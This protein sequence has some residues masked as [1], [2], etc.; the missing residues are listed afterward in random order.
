MDRRQ[1]SRALSHRSVI[2]WLKR[3]ELLL[4]RRLYRMVWD[5]TFKFE[6]DQVKKPGSLRAG[7]F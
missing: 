7:L 2:L 4:G 5:R 3:A 1:K 6:K